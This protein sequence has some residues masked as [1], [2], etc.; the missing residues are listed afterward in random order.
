M[1]IIFISTDATRT[2][3]AVQPVIVRLALQA[4]GRAEGWLLQEFGETNPVLMFV[5]LK[6]VANVDAVYRK[7]ENVPMAEIKKKKT[8][9]HDEVYFAE[10]LPNHTQ[11]VVK[12]LKVMISD[13]TASKK[14]L[15]RFARYCLLLIFNYENLQRAGASCRMTQE[16]CTEMQKMERFCGAKCRGTL[17]RKTAVKPSQNP[18]YYVV[19]LD[20]SRKNI[21]SAIIVKNIV[22]RCSKTVILKV[23][24]YIG[25][26]K[27][28]IEA[29]DLYRGPFRFSQWYSCRRSGR[30]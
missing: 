19:F 15:Y 30:G 23:E 29:N 14:Y 21:V 7:T 27:G 13:I 26:P 5:G 20:D 8:G 24:N 18:I 2:R 12:R 25:Q 10:C 4:T 17:F 22:F 1:P 28:A 11:V 9:K 6:E 3:V 16:H